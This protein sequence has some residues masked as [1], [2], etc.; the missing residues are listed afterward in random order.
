MF[1]ES[2]SRPNITLTIWTGVVSVVGMVCLTLF[3]FSSKVENVVTPHETPK[4]Q[5]PHM[6]QN[7]IDEIRRL[8][9]YKKLLRINGT[10]I[11]VSQ[12]NAEHDE[13]SVVIY[14]NKN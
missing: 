3:I 6:P 11:D 9:P 1:F 4:W 13:D 10:T 7:T 5:L 2:N 12:W 8:Y 14:E